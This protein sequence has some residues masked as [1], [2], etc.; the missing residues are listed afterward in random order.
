MSIHV[1][2]SLCAGSKEDLNELYEK[3]RKKY[4]IKTLGEIKNIKVL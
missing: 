4:K 3:V 2:D 1:D